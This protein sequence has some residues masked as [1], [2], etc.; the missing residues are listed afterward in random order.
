MRTLRCFFASALALALGAVAAC[1]ASEPSP[2]RTVGTGGF[3]GN[4]GASG[5]SGIGG[6]SA[7]GGGIGVD[8]GGGAAARDT[9]LDGPSCA[10]DEHKAE[11]PP[12][13]LFIMLDKSTSMVDP[14]DI[15]NPV[16]GAIRDF[17]QSP[18]AAAAGIGV[19]IGYFPANFDD[20]LSCEIPRYSTPAV[21]IAALP[22]AANGIV[23]S[24]DNTTPG[25]NT[26]TSAALQGALQYAKT[27]AAAHPD[28]QTMVVLATDGDPTICEPT[29]TALIRQYAADALAQAP[30]VFTAVIGMGELGNLNPIAE[31]GGTKQAFIVNPGQQ[32]FAQEL[33]RTLLRLAA[34][35]IGCTFPVPPARDGTRAD[36]TKVNVDYTPIGGAR[37]ELVQVANAGECGRVNNGWYYDNPS[38][39]TTIVICDAVCNGFGAGSLSIVLG[40]ATRVPL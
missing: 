20:V 5:A 11:Q 26:P 36:P 4:A 25:G 9:G 40:C 29:A 32:N 31:G 22:G 33:T 7:T 19:G 13:D 35:P 37:Q 28:R 2:G 30:K 34:A 1:S 14:T 8:S 38:N 18:E 6:F 23:S 10:R 21:Q 16:K 24:M 15:W 3:A 39:P 27:W 12:V 17:L